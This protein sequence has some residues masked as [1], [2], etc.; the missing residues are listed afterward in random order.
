MELR[1]ARLAASSLHDCYCVPYRTET[2]DDL[3]HEST[4]RSHVVHRPL[5][6]LHHSIHPQCCP[7]NSSGLSSRLTLFLFSSATHW[8]SLFLFIS[9]QCYYSSSDAEGVGNLPFLYIVKRFSNLWKLIHVWV[10]VGLPIYFWNLSG[11]TK[12]QSSDRLKSF[13]KSHGPK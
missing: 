3:S 4:R 5:E 9:F 7:W 6:S 11:S 2:I 8:N 13:P 1:T 12:V 10:W